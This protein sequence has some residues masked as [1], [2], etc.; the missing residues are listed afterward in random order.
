VPSPA[1]K[2]DWIGKDSLA[3][4]TQV[5]ETCYQHWQAPRWGS[6]PQVWEGKSLSP[7]SCNHLLPGRWGCER[8]VFTDGPG[9][10]IGTFQLKH[11]GNNPQTGMCSFQILHWRKLGGFGNW[12]FPDLTLEVDSGLEVLNERQRHRESCQVCGMVLVGL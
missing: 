6:V 7:S 2:L 10:E 9:S 5:Q 11:W 3:F 1:R 8:R 4:Q 12:R